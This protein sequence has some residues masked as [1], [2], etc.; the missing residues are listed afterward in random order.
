MNRATIERSIMDWIRDDAP[1]AIKMTMTPETLDKL[2][3]RIMKA[4][5]P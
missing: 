4:V 2:V 3:N 5:K 1:V